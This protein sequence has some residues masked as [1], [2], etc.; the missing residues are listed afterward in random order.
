MFLYF[1]L[2]VTMFISKPHQF[3][4]EAPPFV[5][6]ERRVKRDSNT[7]D[8]D[9]GSPSTRRK[10]ATLSD[11]VPTTRTNYSVHLVPQ[12]KC[13]GITYY[14][15]EKSHFVVKNVSPFDNV[16]TTTIPAVFRKQFQPCTVSVGQKIKE[17]KTAEHTPE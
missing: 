1:Q 7:R 8:H 15:K 16:R 4:P 2:L 10:V 3:V 17:F 11:L 12:G 5:I 9:N 6:H 13:P 14:N